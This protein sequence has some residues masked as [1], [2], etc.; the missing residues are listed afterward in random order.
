M[1]LGARHVP[2]RLCGGRV[3]L[4]RYIKYSTFYLYN[5]YLLT[6]LMHIITISIV[7]H[8]VFSTTAMYVSSADSSFICLV[9]CFIF[10][11]L[12]LFRIV[13]IGYGKNFA[14]IS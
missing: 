1:L 14:D 11:L 8:A 3:Y 7:P 12:T 13:V 5:T 6:Y 4:G 2:E 10:I 9:N